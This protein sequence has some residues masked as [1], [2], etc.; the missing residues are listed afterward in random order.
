MTKDLKDKIEEIKNLV[1]DLIPL[2]ESI[3]STRIDTEGIGGKNI[4][5]KAKVSD[6]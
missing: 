5:S 2:I 6:G 4:R 1:V 3:A